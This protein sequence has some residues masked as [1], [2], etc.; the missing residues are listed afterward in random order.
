MSALVSQTDFS[1]LKLVN[2]GKVRDIYDLGEHLMIVT[3][4]RISAFDVIMD[5]PIPRKGMVL[6]QISKFWFDLMA[7]TIPNNLVSVDVS[8]FPPSA[9]KYAETLSNKRASPAEPGSTGTSTT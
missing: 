6:T 7:D 9:A 1:D 3:S 5:E 4:D 8:D 2:R